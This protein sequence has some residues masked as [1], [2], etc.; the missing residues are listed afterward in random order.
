M[1]DKN[2]DSTLESKFINRFEGNNSFVVRLHSFN[3]FDQNAFDELVNLLELLCTS[4]KNEKYV[5][6]NVAG[7]I[8]LLL[9]ELGNHL[10]KSS[11]HF[12]QA[13]DAFARTYDLAQCI[14]WD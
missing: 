11:K 5:N 7:C 8:N 3:E 9:L 12:K 6:K 1:N 13:N 2:G 10:T 4:L 14:F